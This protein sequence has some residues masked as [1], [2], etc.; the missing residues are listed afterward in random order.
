MWATFLPGMRCTSGRQRQAAAAPHCN[1]GAPLLSQA[2]A[3]GSAAALLLNYT[4]LTCSLAHVASQP[5]NQPARL[6]VG[7]L[8]QTAAA[9]SVCGRFCVCV[10]LCACVKAMGTHCLCVFVCLSVQIA[11]CSI[12]SN[13]LARTLP[14][15][16][17]PASQPAK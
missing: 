9:A 10:R 1:A 5:A 4:P 6:Q 14:V 7:S 15:S 13:W 8:H 3:N 11:Q 16:S 17:Q 2:A 12:A